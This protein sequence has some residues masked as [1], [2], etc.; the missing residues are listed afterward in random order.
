MTT[1]NNNT[2]A[3]PATNPVTYTPGQI[4]FIKFLQDNRTRITVF[5]GDVVS[6]KDLVD[7]LSGSPYVAVP[8]WIAADK[9]RRAGRGNYHLPELAADL[10]ALTV[11]TNKRGRKPGSRNKKGREDGTDATAA[12]D[13]PAL[14]TTTA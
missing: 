8:A 7:V 14:T 13:S 6:R 10:S 5:N 11:N 9:T 4:A 2:A 12:T 3:A 1:N